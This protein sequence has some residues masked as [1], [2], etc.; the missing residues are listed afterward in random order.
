M[1]EKK[2][3]DQSLDGVNQIGW[4]GGRVDRLGLCPG[5]S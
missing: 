3:E 2:E 4:M 1:T 5:H